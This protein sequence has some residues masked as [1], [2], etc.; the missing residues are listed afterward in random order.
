MDQRRERNMQRKLEL[1][2]IDSGDYNLNAFFELASD[3]YEELDRSS[4]VITAA[5][6]LKLS[7]LRNRW[8]RIHWPA[9]DKSDDAPWLDD[10]RELFPRHYPAFEKMC[11]QKAAL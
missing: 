3:I 9:V 5:T 2:D 1:F 10:C 6:K 11:R 4:P 8:Y 7:E